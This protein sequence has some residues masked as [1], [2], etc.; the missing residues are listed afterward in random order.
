MWGEGHKMESQLL[1]TKEW[2]RSLNEKYYKNFLTP[3]ELDKMSTGKDYW[4]TTNDVV[5]RL[6]GYQAAREAEREK[7]LEETRQQAVAQA[8]QVIEQYKPKD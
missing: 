5:E 7:G 3:E 1:A 2:V 8:E 6:E 4:F